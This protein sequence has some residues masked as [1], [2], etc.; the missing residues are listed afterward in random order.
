[1]TIMIYSS[2]LGVDS[3]GVVS[4]LTDVTLASIGVMIRSIAHRG[5]NSLFLGHPIDQ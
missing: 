4:R 3:V 2:G 1:M 5:R